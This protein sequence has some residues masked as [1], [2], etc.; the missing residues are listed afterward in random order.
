M[1][2]GS[3]EKFCDIS[4]AYYIQKILYTEN[5]RSEIFDGAETSHLFQPL[6]RAVQGLC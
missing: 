2:I 1:H 3:E 4:L 6:F 5:I